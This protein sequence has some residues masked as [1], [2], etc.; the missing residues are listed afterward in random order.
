M[1]SILS[2]P[3]CS[4]WSRRN[5]VRFI[6]IAVGWESKLGNSA[7]NGDA[8]DLVLIKL[9]K[10]ER[11]TWSCSNPVGP[12]GQGGSRWDGK[13]SDLALYGDTPYQTPRAGISWP[14]ILDEPQCP[15]GSCRNSLRTARES[16]LGDLAT[17]GDA[18][19][20]A[21]CRGT[22]K[23]CEPE[24]PG[25]PGR[26]PLNPTT[27]WQGELSDRPLD[28]DPS[29]LVRTKLREPEGGLHLVPP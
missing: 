18:P 4:I 16:K 3:E 5:L 9:G 20:L 21:G 26:D 24:R 27:S 29:D 17:N 2:E 10:P 8:P 23:F 6:G 11:S 19:D 28:A 14:S 22:S 15:I 12:V 25:G 7:L 1:A 13:L